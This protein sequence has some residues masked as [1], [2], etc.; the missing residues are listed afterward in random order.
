MGILFSAIYDKAIA[1]FDDPKVTRAYET[2]KL[3][4]DKIM[5]TY[6]QNAISMFNNPLSVSLRLSKYNEPQGTMEVFEG[7]GVDKTFLLSTDFVIVDN[8]VYQY[9]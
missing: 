3:Q 1:L 9:I 5:Y 8:S 7:N 4:F 2:N 6:L